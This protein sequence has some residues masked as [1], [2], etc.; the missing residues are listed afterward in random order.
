[1]SDFAA[2]DGDLVERNGRATFYG[3]LGCAE[4]GV[5]LW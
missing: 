1:V 3:H 2:A 5:H 4:V